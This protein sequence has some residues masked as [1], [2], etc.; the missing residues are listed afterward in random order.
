M[1]PSKE[2]ISSFYLIAKSKPY[3]TLETQLIEAVKLSLQNE[4]YGNASFL[5]ERLVAEINN[6]ETRHLL[7][8][9]YIGMV[10]DDM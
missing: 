8:E 4:L 6:E 9:C 3:T 2:S 5:C 10:C 7:A 1:I